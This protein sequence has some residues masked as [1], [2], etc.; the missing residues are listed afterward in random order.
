MGIIEI[1]IIGIGLAMDAFAVAICKGLSLRN[2]EVTKYI[3]VG[4]YFGI[5]QGLMPIIGYILGVSFQNIITKVDHWVA[6][7]LLGVIGINMIKESFSKENRSVTD[8]V[9]FKT[10]FPL[11][12]A[13]SIDALAVGI[14]FAFLKV[15]IVTATLIIT[16]TTFII[17]LFGVAIGNKFGS[18]YEHRAEFIGGLI[19]VLMCLK[20]LL[21]HLNI[22]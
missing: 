21:D 3:I 7:I 17:S 2:K 19:L 14:T 12:L 6:F 4:S 11:A 16:V 10:M 13:T 22:M 15:N 5:F 8:K 20:I 18:K 1:V 9:N